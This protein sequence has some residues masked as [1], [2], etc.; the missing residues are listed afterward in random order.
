[1]LLVSLFTILPALY[2]YLSFN[3][4]KFPKSIFL[5]ISLSWFLG[6]YVNTFLI[7]I[8][9][10]ILHFFTASVLSKASWISL[11]FIGLVAI[12][13]MPEVKK[14]VIAMGRKIVFKR[15]AASTV[16]AL[17]CLV[18]SYFLFK[19][20]LNQRQGII[21]TSP[22]FWDFKFYFSNI[23]NFVYGDNFP[24]ENV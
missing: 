5:R 1:M 23:Q 24:P 20:H 7:Y 19:P 2:C 3:R 6:Q 10:V 8:L 12:F 21:Y 22:V 15:L 13:S 18:F 16:I 9:A 11:G 14:M 17:G 4:Y